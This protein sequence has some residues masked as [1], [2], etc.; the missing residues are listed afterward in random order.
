MKKLLF[1]VFIM[2][3]C[4]LVFFPTAFSQICEI[5]NVIIQPSKDAYD[6]TENLTAVL[7]FDYPNTEVSYV[8][9]WKLYD[10]KGGLLI[11]KKE[12]DKQVQLGKTG[13]W[14]II[15][16]PKDIGWLK[17]GQYLMEI[18][19][20]G[21]CL[22]DNFSK[23]MNTSFFVMNKCTD[24][25]RF[26]VSEGDF[27]NLKVIA[28]DP[29]NDKLT[30]SYSK[31]LSSDGTW[32]TGYNDAGN[33]TVTVMVS[34]GKINISSKII[35]EVMNKNQPPVIKTD[36]KITVTEEE[37]V[38]LKINVTDPDGD[39]V[40]YTISGWMN[41]DEKKTGLDD[42]GEHVVTVTATDKKDTVKKD[43]IVEVLNK[44][45][46]PE[47]KNEDIEINE[48]TFFELEPEVYD[49][50]QDELQVKVEGWMTNFSRYVGFEDAGEHKVT[51]T[52][53]D[54]KATEKKTITITVKNVNRA[55]DWPQQ[56]PKQIV[57][58]NSLLE[59]E[60]LATDPDGQEVKY[61]IKDKDS[62]ESYYIE[63]NKFYWPITY[64]YLTSGE[65]TKHIIISASDGEKETLKDIEV[66]IKNKNRAPIINDLLPKK[67]IFYLNEP[68]NFTTIATDPDGDALTYTYDFG[69]LDSHT[70]TKSSH[71]RKFTEPGTKTMKV[72]VSDGQLQTVKEYK[73]KVK[74]M[75]FR[76]I[77][78]PNVSAE[79][80]VEDTYTQYEIEN[81]ETGKNK[82]YVIE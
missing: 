48:N 5:R 46:P 7:R 19:L 21:K 18:N 35:I 13:T 25:Q 3:L 53:T 71:I 63:G 70:D 66:I 6:C 16:I 54:G 37:R 23:N 61:F 36:E 2:V 33:Y 31:P 4:F 17:E 55:P 20:N 44:N 14:T 41:S 38:K 76:K 74:D 68:V 40:T 11:H 10:P 27:I 78:Y 80:I 15:A 22:M 77:T 45:Q 58:E 73:I 12:K 69:L 39:N 59:L 60:L 47:I 28:E 52:A 57:S 26:K 9:E 30:Y 72:V 43:V 42:Q 24:L 50:D 79:I 8:L 81:K 82:I 34:D 65:V 29:D 75:S 67:R 51:I 64:D 62:K 32:Q 1:I 49:P 56:I